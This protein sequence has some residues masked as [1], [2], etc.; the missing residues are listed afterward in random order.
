MILNLLVTVEFAAQ[1]ARLEMKMVQSGLFF[2]QTSTFHHL[3]HIHIKSS[4]SPSSFLWTEKTLC[5]WWMNHFRVGHIH[6]DAWKYS[7]DMQFQ[8]M[9]INEEI[10]SYYFYNTRTYAHTHSSDKLC[11]DVI[12]NTVII[13][14]VV[15]KNCVL[16]KQNAHHIMTILLLLSVWRRRE[17]NIDFNEWP[18]RKWKSYPQMGQNCKLFS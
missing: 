4:E 9:F 18:V 10:F 11:F 7:S 16:N 6:L 8:P 1:I 13:F 2:M 15:C 14:K 3:Y 5:K 17:K 12:F